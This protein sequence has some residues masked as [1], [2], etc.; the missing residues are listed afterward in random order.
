MDDSVGVAYTVWWDPDFLAVDLQPPGCCWLTPWG[1][2]LPSHTMK[3]TVLPGI[4]SSR[5]LPQNLQ[6]HVLL[7]ALVIVRDSQEATLA[8]TRLH[9]PDHLFRNYQGCCL[10][11]ACNWILFAR[12]LLGLR[13]LLGPRLC[14]LPRGSHIWRLARGKNACLTPVPKCMLWVQLCLP[15]DISK[16]YPRPISQHLRM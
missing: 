9:H 1:M 15:K 16:I 10:L 6:S 7:E 8:D 4:G 12:T 14:P 2:V 3:L 5:W 11:G 13:E